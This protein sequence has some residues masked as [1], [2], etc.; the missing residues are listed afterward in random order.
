MRK[1]GLDERAISV[2]VSSIYG[3][4]FLLG[5]NCY[6]SMCVLNHVRKEWEYVRLKPSG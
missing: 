1:Y 2:K 3:V 5:G 6:K 4:R